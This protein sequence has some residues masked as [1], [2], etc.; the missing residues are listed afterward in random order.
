MSC[1]PRS[2]STRPC[3]QLEPRR[4]QPGSE[5]SSVRGRPRSAWNRLT[6]GS[7][8]RPSRPPVAGQ[9]RSP[10]GWLA[11]SRKMTQ[12]SFWG[13]FER[14]RSNSGFV[15][16]HST[17]AFFSAASAGCQPSLEHHAY[18]SRFAACGVSCR[19]LG[20]ARAARVLA[21]APAA[22]GSWRWFAWNAAADLDFAA[23]PT[24]G[25]TGMNSVSR[26]LDGLP[27]LPLRRRCGRKRDGRSVNSSSR[28]RCRPRCSITKWSSVKLASLATT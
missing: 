21:A 19:R 1:P 9:G 17:A 2:A 3:R 23:S 25:Y 6:T 7:S 15:H 10:A 26:V 14:Q 27:R 8:P 4:R 12:V 16:C 18:R 24:Y 28:C 22:K 11:T 13:F 5:S 20:L